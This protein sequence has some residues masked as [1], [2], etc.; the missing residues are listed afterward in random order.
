MVLTNLKLKQKLGNKTDSKTDFGE[1]NGEKLVRGF[2]IHTWTYAYDL[3][4][5]YDFNERMNDN[6]PS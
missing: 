2:L 6:A 4:P 1:L 5:S 3:I